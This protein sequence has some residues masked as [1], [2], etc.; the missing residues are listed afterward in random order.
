MQL[1]CKLDG[2]RTLLGVRAK[3]ATEKASMTYLKQLLPAA[4]ALAA[5]VWLAGATAP[6]NAF[7]TGVCP[8]VGNDTDCQIGITLQSNGTGTIEGGLNNGTYDG[9][10]DTLVGIVNSTSIP[11]SPIY[12]WRDIDRPPSQIT[13]GKVLTGEQPLPSNLRDGYFAPRP[14]VYNDLAE[15]F[16]QWWRDYHQA[17]DCS[18][19]LPIFWIS[20]RSGS[21]KSVALLHLLAHIHSN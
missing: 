11:K 13:S 1:A 16:F 18:L 3:K 6:A 5:V 10:A 17:G 21:G 4:A 9:V 20:G 19:R 8:A 7:P 2:E 14:D 12:I 15:K